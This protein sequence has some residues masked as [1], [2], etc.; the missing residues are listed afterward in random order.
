MEVLREWIDK[1]ASLFTQESYEAGLPLP[2][3]IL[4]MGVSG[5]G[6][7]LAAKTVAAIWKV[8]IF[9]LD[10]NV[11]FSGLYG[12][13]EA[14]FHQALKTIESVAPAVVWI[15]EIENGLGMRANAGSTDQNQIFSAFLT[16]MQEKPPMI[17]VAATANHI[18]SLPAEIIRKGRFDQVF[19]C[20]L[21][22][23]E[24]RDAIFKIHLARNGADVDA[25][26]VAYLVIATEGWNGAE[27]EQ[28]VI[29]ARIDAYTDNRA[30]T[31]RDVSRHIRSN[32]PLSETM[33][34]QI[35]A[36]RE[37][38]WGRATTASKTKQRL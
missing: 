23:N 20:D 9:R 33:A 26:D 34:E 36:I 27:I 3:G 31:T 25:I 18:E 10:F 5:C 16:W 2:K 30:M 28:V 32:V 4:L 24:E 22:G 11:I 19:F 1:R 13:P 38:A 15:D 29:A 12:S 8:P 7:S 6:K 21:P 35:K 37:W 17:F 14:T